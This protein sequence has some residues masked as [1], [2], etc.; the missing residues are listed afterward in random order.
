M[1]TKQLDYYAKLIQD[2]DTKVA[3]NVKAKAEKARKSKELQESLDQRVRFLNRER[4]ELLDFL[5]HVQRV[6]K[7]EN[8][9]RRRSMEASYDGNNHK[10]ESMKRSFSLP[11]VNTHATQ[12]VSK[13]KS[14]D[15]AATIS[16]CNTG[17]KKQRKGKTVQQSKQSKKLRNRQSNRKPG[18]SSKLEEEP[19]ERTCDKTLDTKE[20]DCSSGVDTLDIAVIPTSERTSLPPL[21]KNLHR[22]NFKSTDVTREFSVNKK[23][24][25]PLTSSRLIDIESHRTNV[26]LKILKW[27]DS[28]PDDLFLPET[29]SKETLTTEKNETHCLAEKS[30]GK[31][32]RMHEGNITIASPSSKLY[33]SQRLHVPVDPQYRKTEPKCVKGVGQTPLSLK[34]FD[35]T[36]KSK[37]RKSAKKK[38]KRVTF[39]KSA[40]EKPEGRPIRVTTGHANNGGYE[41][42]GVQNL[43][44]VIAT[45]LELITNSMKSFHTCKTYRGQNSLPIRTAN[46]QAFRNLAHAQVRIVRRQRA[47]RDGDMYDYGKHI[48]SQIKR[49][50]HRKL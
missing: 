19:C 31:S 48:D 38:K 33:T 1:N 2:L 36:K 25:A 24:W 22:G 46:S 10:E 8:G 32:V 30:G 4:H 20:S 17:N 44:T 28:I 40:L 12:I 26:D 37:A 35:D 13:E 47:R 6:K 14:D 7:P 49:R 27:F 16:K 11:N 50:H 45:D 39:Y 29:I 43:S 3:V 34:T 18:S 5:A 21:Y 23:P 42:A 41:D 9:F 15:I